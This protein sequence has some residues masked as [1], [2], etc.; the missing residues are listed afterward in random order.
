MKKLIGLL[1][2]IALPL[3]SYGQNID[4]T[5]KL[6]AKNQI[7][8]STQKLYPYFF[9]LDVLS[10][11]SDWMSHPQNNS[12]AVECQFKLRP[13]FISPKIISP[14]CYFLRQDDKNKR[15]MALEIVDF[16][17]NSQGLALVEITQDPRY[18]QQAQ[19]K[20]R[21]FLKS[22]NNDTKALHQCFRPALQLDW[23]RAFRDGKLIYSPFAALTS[24]LHT[25]PKV[26]ATISL[27]DQTS[28]RAMPY[29]SF[30]MALEFENHPGHVV[31]QTGWIEGNQVDYLNINDY[32]PEVYQKIKSKENIVEKLYPLD[33]RGSLESMRKLNLDDVFT[34]QEGFF[35]LENH[36]IWGQKQGIFKEIIQSLSKAQES[37]FIDMFF[38]GG[39]TGTAM[40]KY[41]IKLLEIN[42]TLKI[43]IL[44]DNINHLTYDK[45]MKPVFNFLM[46]YSEKHPKRLLISPSHLAAHRSGL[47]DFLAPM[48]N[49]SFLSLI[50]VNNSWQ[51]SLAP[52]HLGVK[53]D[54]SKVVVI[55]GKSARPVAFVGSKNWLDNSGAICY[56]DVAKVTGPGAAVVLDD[57]YWDMYYALRFQ[58]SPTYIAYLARQGWS[59]SLFYEG[60][61]INQMI[62][63]ILRPFDLLERDGKGMA[64]P[65]ARVL[66]PSSGKVK[67]RTGANN[68]DSSIM[69]AVDQDI[70]SI[71]FAKKR[72]YINDQYVFDRNIINALL[73]AKKN[74]P[75]LDIRLLMAPLD[76]SP[77]PGMPNLLFADILTKA[78]IKIKLKK[79]G[80]DVQIRQ[81]YHMKTISI[82]GQYVIVGSANKDL[83][84]MMGSF[85]EEQFD[86]Y[87]PQSA[88][89][90]DQ[91]FLQR[92][93]DSRESGPQFE[94]Y[95][96]L[97]MGKMTG[98]NGLND[99]KLS[100]SQLVR[101]IRASLSV[102]FDYVSL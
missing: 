25:L 69:S 56:D 71:L 22:F 64:N 40:A 50:K 19:N 87:D 15:M 86:L 83:T 44:R 85:R 92:W 1:F 73:K 82:D 27:G 77:L 55:D 94:K 51:Q 75:H 48:I 78:G 39:T 17:V 16:Y 31:S 95:D 24:C 93:N 26:S 70:Q 84:T 10:R 90:H 62:S 4:L 13:F 74:N 14:L 72:I 63:Q 80:G 81:E 20:A 54:H 46:A 43:F 23:A 34:I 28:V 3:F 49:D 97:D 52:I 76:D 2:F 60:Q 47:P 11:L 91:T 98:F 29:F 8:L 57:Y 101:Y 30:N 37:I 7:T 79:I 89:I 6:K 65:K 67:L 61:N 99:Q 35:S 53:S 41:L 12:Y 21:Q 42:P 58:L 18:N 38:F 88:A 5:A 66:I 32:S 100:V 68:V 59:S 96:D 36:P 102:L 33:G 9:D 45:Q